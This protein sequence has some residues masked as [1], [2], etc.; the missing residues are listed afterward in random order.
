[1]LLPSSGRVLLKYALHTSDRV[2]N[3]PA[4][5]RRGVRELYSGLVQAELKN[6]LS[7][8]RQVGSEVHWISSG[9]KV[10]KYGSCDVQSICNISA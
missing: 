5:F 1:M 8:F 9:K 4:I 7:F 3:T 2:K 10:V 6:T